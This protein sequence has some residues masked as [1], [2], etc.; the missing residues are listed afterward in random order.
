MISKDKCLE[1]SVIPQFEGT[2]WFNAILMIALYSENVRKVL[3]MTSKHWDKSNS[4]LMILKR[5]LFI[6]YK[7]PDKVQ[8][9]FNKIKPEAILLK[10]LKTY[11]D[12]YLLDYL[13]KKNKEEIKLGYFIDYISKFLKFIGINVLHVVY[14]IKFGY[15]LNINNEIETI[16]DEKAGY[17]KNFTKNK[18]HFNDKDFLENKEKEVFME[19]K[20]ILDDIPNIIILEHEI[21]FDDDFLNY[22]Y[23][24]ISQHINTY[25]SS[26][27]NF[28]VKGLDTYEDII[29]L[30]GYKYKLDSV[31]LSN[32]N[33]DTGSH[34]IV[35]I[36]CN[37]N[38]YVYNGWNADSNDSG[39][40]NKV[41]QTSP[42]SLMKYEW[43]L[44]KDNDFCLNTKTCKL[45]FIDPNIEN[46]ELC[47]SF[48]K[49]KRILIYV[50]LDDTIDSNKISKVDFSSMTPTLSGVSDVIKEIHN[51]DNL[52]DNELR[53]LLFINFKLT[54]LEKNTTEQL[55]KI[56]YDSLLIFY[57]IKKKSKLSKSKEEK[58]QKT[59]PN[60]SIK[61]KLSINEMI[62]RLNEKGIYLVSNFKYTPEIIEGLYNQYVIGRRGGKRIF[63]KYT[64]K[65]K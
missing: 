36:T 61:P 37:G 5:I 2:C 50:K 29:E 10:M 44:K 4:F 30:N 58:P 62:K 18:E 43:N 16:Y 21:L 41:H 53:K 64:S 54:G 7:Q 15:Y 11:N 47:F 31:A 33:K 51:I 38:R 25:K 39:L 52:S 46:E 1:L 48:A 55:K 3:M 27:Y 32:Y 12:K 13:K 57:N 65:L 9:F 6:Y 23:H 60:S 40:K 45:D 59:I 22:T 17:S 56:Y 8:T 49:G 63:K 26:Y 20:K 35:G 42:C 28:N 34:A 24:Y 19:N 14:S